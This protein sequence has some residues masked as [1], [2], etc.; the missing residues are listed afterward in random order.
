MAADGDKTGRGPSASDRALWRRAM[1]DARKLDRPDSR[2]EDPRAPATPRVRAAPAQPV[3][4]P[5]A[6]APD[7][8]PAVGAGLDR[9]TALRFRRGQMVIDGRLDLHG[10]TQRDAYGA[11][12]SFIADHAARGSRCLLIIT[13]IGR[14]GGDGGAGGVLRR[15]VPRWLQDRALAREVL[16]TAQA[17]VRDGGAGAL[18]V[19]LR[20]K[21]GPT[22]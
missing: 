19:L 7:P 1:E 9:R 14:R 22:S 2:T 18:Y 12:A 20:R 15:E 16:A 11:V 5:R 21:R 8:A 13:G 6:R 17:Q 4:P 10:F 3:E